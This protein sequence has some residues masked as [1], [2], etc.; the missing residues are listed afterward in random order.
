MQ[1]LLGIDNGGTMTKAALFTA[2]GAEV[3]S[4]FRETPVETPQTGYYERDMDTLWETTAAC[5]REALGRAGIDGSAVIG[6]GCT[7][8]GKGLYLWGRDGRPAAKAVASTDS[9]AAS[10]VS[11][12]ERRGIAQMAADR[13]MQPVTACQPA[14][15]LAWFQQHRPSVLENT[16][17]IFEAKDYLR[18]R[19]TGEALAEVTDY[20][21]TSLMDLHTGDFN[22]ELLELWG[23]RE[24]YDRLPP[25]CLSSDRAGRVTREAAQQTGLQPGTPVCGGM[26]DIDACAVA[27][28]VTAPE[29]LCAITG[30]WSI[31]EYPSPLPAPVG[32]TTRTSL[33]CVPGLY[34][35]EESSPTSA[36]NLE[37]VLRQFMKAEGQEAK[38]KGKRLYDV[39]DSLVDECPPEACDTV[40]LPYL[41][42]SPADT[43]VQAAFIGLN[44]AHSIR[45]ILRAVYEGVVFSHLT[46]IEKLLSLRQPPE[47][48]RL[49]GGAVNSRIWTQMFADILG[50][51]IETVRTRELGAKGSAMAA[52]VATGLYRDY[53]E[54][55]AGMVQV[56][57]RILPREDRRAVYRRKYERYRQASRLL[58]DMEVTQSC[59]RN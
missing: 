51:P 15:L 23:L 29:R 7:G 59:S 13:T 25:P 48:V 11:E 31:N 40:F 45:H 19:L 54:A 35:I 8:H 5:I 50:L 18:F 20:S 58:V 30:T 27:M 14:A 36:G 4:A 53:R 34:L 16:R 52:A 28:D 37:W 47:A 17:W 41:Y 42:G 22:R 10:I 1:Y 6:V 32:G 43:P 9:R 49:A 26:F 2:D 44:S 24:L 57:E 21:G 46:H 12:W 56:A 39:A 33:F 55:A 38:L 3:A